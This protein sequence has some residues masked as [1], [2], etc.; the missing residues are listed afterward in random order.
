MHT[1]TSPAGL[2]KA[3]EVQRHFTAVAARYDLANDILSFGLQ[4]SWKRRAVRLLDLMPGA[5]VADI[6]GG[7]G[8]LALLAAQR[9]GDTGRLLLYDFNRDMLLRGRDKVVK[10]GLQGVIFPVQGD[11]QALALPDRC[12]DAVMVGFGIRNLTDMA[13]GFRE[14]HRV[15]KPGGR[16]LCLEFSQPV[17]PWFRTLYDLY[18]HLVIPLAGKLLAGSFAAYSYLTTSIRAFPDPETLSVLLTRIGFRQVAYHRLTNGIAVV[19]VGVKG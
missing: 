19:H 1:G 3:A 7:T 17:S 5:W 6:C 10:A 2:S 13:A 18:S 8:D 14:M 12:L 11:A 4:R 15:L 16:L 9:V